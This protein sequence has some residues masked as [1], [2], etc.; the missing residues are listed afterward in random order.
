MK[1]TINSYLDTGKTNT[2]PPASNTNHGFT[3][4][5]KTHPIL[6]G[7]LILIGVLIVGLGAFVLIRATNLTNKIF[8]GDNNSLFGQ[9]T[10]LLGGVKLQGE[11]QGQ[12]NILLLGMGGS[13]HDGPYLTDSII[14]A[15]IRPKDKK[16]AMV[17]VPRD[18]LVNLGTEF[19]WRKVNAAFA[20]SYEKTKDFNQAGKTAREAVEQISGL[21]IPYFAVIDFKGFEQAIDLVDGIDVDIERTFTDYTYPDNKFG[22]LPAVTFKQG[23]EHMNGKRALIFARSRHAAGPEGTDFARSQRQQKMLQAFKSRV[24]ELNLITESGKINSLLGV[25]GDHFHTNIGLAEMYHL[26]EIGK[27]YGK[28][29][30]TTLSLDP[31]T[32]LVCDGKQEET[33][34]YIVEPCS[35]VTKQDIKNFFTNSFTTAGIVSEKSTIWL[36]DS[37]TTG[38]L[39]AKAAATLKDTGATI[40]ELEYS[41]N[42]LQQN[43]V[44]QVNDKPSTLQYIKDNLQAS[45]VTLPPPGVKVDKTKTDFIIILGTKSN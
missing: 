2:P 33:G 8:V 15:Q 20:E 9:V 24:V 3:L 28:D 36:A 42:P 21:T 23:M 12:I 25:L 37:S 26:Y 35:G 43:V 27:D 45:Q 40:L 44:Y 41:G 13:G 19:G 10:N 4:P 30:V 18:Y 1:P 14:V 31:A 34:A 7:V 32:E 39:Y 5:K 11:D 17:S 29:N 6:K 22:Y 16:V 38:K